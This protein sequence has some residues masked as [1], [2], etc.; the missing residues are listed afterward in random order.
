LIKG[1]VVLATIVAALAIV[2]NAAAGLPDGLGPWADYVVA[3]NQGCAYIPNDFT[4]CQNVR[5]DR[6][7]PQAAVGPAESPQGPNNNP[8]P[9]GTFYSLGFTS[10]QRGTAFI[11]LGFDNAIC[12]GPGNDM[13]I[14][15][16][17]ITKEPYPPETVN[18]YVSQDNVNYVFAGTVTKDGSVG[19]PA[20]IPFV[21]FVKLV[22]VTNPTLFVNQTPD[23]DG[24]DL[25][26]VE[27]LQPPTACTGGQ[28][29]TLEICKSGANNMYGRT[30]TFTVDGGTPITVKGGRCT[31][32]F[33]VP[34][35]AVEIVEGL[36]NPPTDVADITVRPSARLLIKDVANRRVVVFVPQGSTGANETMVTFTD[37]PAGGSVGDLKI[38]KLTSAP[39]LV[40][41][42]FSF[43]VNGGALL[44]TPANA[45]AS[46]PSTWSCRDVG[47][48]QAGTVVNVREAIPPGIAISFFDSVPASALGTFDTG[49][50]TANVTISGPVTELQVD[51]E[52]IPPAQTGYIEVCKD[53][54]LV[55][56]ATS[57]TPY[58]DPFVK[59]TFTFTVSPANG[60][61]FTVSTVAG[62]CT[63]AVQVPA[64][65]VRVTEQAQPN[66]NL[67]DAFSIPDSAEVASNIINGTI[68]VQ[69]PVSAT[70]NGE[71]QVHFVNQALRSQLKICK[72]LGANSAGLVGMSFNFTVSSPDTPASFPSVTVSTPGAVPPPDAACVVVGDYPV[73]YNVNVVEN[74][75]RTTAPG[76]FIDTTGEGTYPIVA[77]TSNIVTITNTAKATLEICKKLTD[78]WTAAAPQFGFRVDGGALQIVTASIN[79]GPLKCL[80]L[81]VAPGLHTVTEVNSANFE[82]DPNAAGM[83]ITVSPAGNAA[84]PPDLPNRTVTVNLPFASDTFTTFTNRIRRFQIK[85]CK[86][87]TV[88][89]SEPLSSVSF[90]YNISVNGA[91]STLNGVTLNQCLVVPGDFPVILPNGANNQVLIGEQSASQVMPP[92]FGTFYVTGI[93][94]QFRKTGAGTV[95]ETNCVTAPYSPTGQHC[96][97]LTTATANTYHVRF[98][99]G[100][101]TNEA[102]FT[103][104]AG[105]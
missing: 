19:I 32:A 56:G 94:V 95:Y 29:G 20:S 78:Q 22:D 93:A 37:Q 100:P 49:A 41:Q 23:I 80:T 67:I 61:P 83:G 24:Y 58:P 62:S 54:A 4:T 1:G 101:G 7:D 92:P 105:G 11:T 103:N 27:S 55:T 104:T 17:E 70:T 36:T 3:N 57:S 52:P 65:L 60:T 63:Q 96:L 25:D 90:N 40:G 26:G 77:G 34:L 74:L 42:L 72:A 69:V 33:S 13:A 38:C 51:D 47:T 35:G 48:F 66:I 8:I 102:D 86:F 97:Y 79:N 91:T 76:S 6:S 30:F 64:G 85:V 31:G 88:G 59:G 68:D 50:G 28:T 2:G 82:L 46:D 89:S 10:P 98:T 21:N 99:P 44:S 43:S 73:G 71:T 84:G 16:Y 18:V 45:E 81:R 14:L 53:R 15:L 9:V 12:N 87:A 5:P 75:D 39:T